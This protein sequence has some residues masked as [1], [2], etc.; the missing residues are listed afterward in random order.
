MLNRS[1]CKYYPVCGGDSCERCGGYTP[2]NAVNSVSEYVTTLDDDDSIVFLD[3]YAGYTVAD[4]EDGMLITCATDYD[5]ESACV[6][7]SYEEDG[8]VVVWVCER[9]DVR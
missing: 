1:D 8:F 2:V 9:G 5:V 4:Y 3:L 7:D 6:I